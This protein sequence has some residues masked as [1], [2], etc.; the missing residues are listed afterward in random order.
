VIIA[1]S[2]LGKESAAKG[3]NSISKALA[4]IEG[5]GFFCFD[6]ISS[7]QALR[8]VMTN[9]KFRS[10]VATFPEFSFLID[11]IKDGKDSAMSGM[12]AELLDIF[13]KNSVDSEYGGAVM[14]N[15]INNRG[16]MNAPAF[17]FVGD[18]TPNFYDGVTEQMCSSGF[19]SRLLLLHNDNPT[20]Y[21][22]DKTAHLV[23]LDKDVLDELSYLVQQVKNKH[24]SGTFINVTYKD[25]EVEAAAERLQS[26]L[27][28][29]YNKSKD[30]AHH[31][32]YGRTWLKV[33]TIASLFAACNNLGN[34]TISMEDFQWAQALVMRDVFTT[35][36]KLR[37][38]EMGISESTCRLRCSSFIEKLVFKPLSRDS[39]A[40]NAEA[41][42][43]LGIIPRNLLSGKLQGS[44]FQIGNMTSGKTLDVILDGMCKDGYISVVSDDQKAFLNAALGKNL[45]GVLYVLNHPSTYVKITELEMAHRNKTSP[46]SVAS[47]MNE[48]NKKI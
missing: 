22:A 5:D 9:S 10:V 48:S 19:M 31:Q 40:K 21:P 38:G 42:L 2:T 37:D 47:A 8:S 17:S 3:M 26:Y 23:K 14:A 30:E 41:I 20:K 25:A 43:N 16:S 6:K 18:C 28:I 11:Q 1:G 27:L 4:S 35:V 29:K 39:K 45:R 13:G 12:Y 7:P 24:A 33:M 44:S 32:A 15:V 46:E 36:Q 34:P